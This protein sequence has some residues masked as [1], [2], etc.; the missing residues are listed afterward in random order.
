MNEVPLLS[1]ENYKTFGRTA[2]YDS[3]RFA[4]DLEI[5]LKQEFK[6]IKKTV[7]LILNDG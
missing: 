7:F 6:Q 5:L 4:I 2:F 3:I 1:G